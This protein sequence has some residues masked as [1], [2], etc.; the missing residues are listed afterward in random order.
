MIDRIQ[1]TTGDG[2]YF[3]DITYYNAEMMNESD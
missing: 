3:Q 2:G 1:E